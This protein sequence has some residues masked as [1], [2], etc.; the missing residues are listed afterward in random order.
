ME[1]KTGTATLAVCLAISF[2]FQVAPVTA[3]Y[4][5]NVPSIFYPFGT[6]QDDS[7]APVNDD[8]S[9]APTD[10]SIGFPFFNSVNRQLYVSTISTLHIRNNAGLK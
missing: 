4:D 9:T 5:R 8:G 7:I 6:D 3:L 1:D 10:I 2:V